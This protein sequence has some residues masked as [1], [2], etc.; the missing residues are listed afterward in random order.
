MDPVTVTLMAVC[1]R[2]LMDGRIAVV[3]RTFF[4]LF[5]VWFVTSS[6]PIRWFSCSW[7]WKPVEHRLGR[8]NNA[9][10]GEVEMEGTDGEGAYLAKLHSI[11]SRA[12]PQ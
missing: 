8:M 2:W 12:R 1:G 7:E 10:W 4:Q 3:N 9:C 6:F 11:A 5:T